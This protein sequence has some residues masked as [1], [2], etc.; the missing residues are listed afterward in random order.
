[1]E[2]I[3]GRMLASDGVLDDLYHA[4]IITDA[5]KKS[6]KKLKL[7]RD[8][9]LK[10]SAGSVGGSGKKKSSAALNSLIKEIMAGP[11][12]PKTKTASAKSQAVKPIKLAKSTVNTD[13]Q[14][15]S[16]RE[17][18]APSAQDIIRKTAT[19]QA[20]SNVAEARRLVESVR[21]GGSTA[22]TPVKLSQSFF[23]GGR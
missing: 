22:R 14:S 7:G 16:E 23:R 3:G 9:Q 17:I 21:G 20:T 10:S 11:D 15:V 5:E 12:V 2:S 13:I 8:G 19:P 18:V 1:V 4:G 6:L